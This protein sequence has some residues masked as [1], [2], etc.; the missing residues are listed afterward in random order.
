[1]RPLKSNINSFLLRK[2]INKIFNHKS[3]FCSQQCVNV[4]VSKK[5]AKL[6]KKT[7]NKKILYSKHKLYWLYKQ[8][9][10]DF[11]IKSVASN[12]FK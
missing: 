7:R 2:T 6:H 1:M 4:S 10:Q 9:G 3:L 8:R 11:R 5:Q 12:L